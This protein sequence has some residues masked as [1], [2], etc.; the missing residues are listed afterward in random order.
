MDRKALVK[1]KLPEMPERITSLRYKYLIEEK[2]VSKEF[3][4]RFVTA[5]NS[6]DNNDFLIFGGNI[7]LQIL[8]HFCLKDG[9]SKRELEKKKR[10]PSYLVKKKVINRSEGHYLTG[11][12]RERKFAIKKKQANPEYYAINFHIFTMFVKKVENRLLEDSKK[13]RL[14]E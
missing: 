5:Y 6:G 8:E 3:I 11:F 9:I 7:I 2:I 4:K 1:K 10:G 13:I 12:L 14:G